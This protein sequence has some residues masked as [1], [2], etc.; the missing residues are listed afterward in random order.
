MNS[1]IEKRGDDETGK[2]NMII[3]ISEEVHQMFR[4]SYDSPGSALF[5]SPLVIRH[6]G[7][8]MQAYYT[9]C[10]E[11][12]PPSLISIYTIVPDAILSFC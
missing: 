6:L 7:G 4:G 11:H 12:F 9:P 1:I 8:V 3:I 10:K 2:K 5:N